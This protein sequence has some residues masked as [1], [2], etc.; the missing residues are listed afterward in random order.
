MDAGTGATW[1]KRN[2]TE[3]GLPPRSFG[4]N[5]APLL[6]QSVVEG[7]VF[8]AGAMSL[9]FALDASSGAVLWSADTGEC[10]HL[11]MVPAVANGTVFAGCDNGTLFAFEVATGAQRW[12]AAV[13]GFAARSPAV[14]DGRVFVGFNGQH[15][16]GSSDKLVVYA[17]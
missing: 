3:A 6:A 14:A 12:S 10:G 11:W 8:V 5:Y 16:A 13:P 17:A 15:D 1:W 7:R 2:L 9:L 4:A